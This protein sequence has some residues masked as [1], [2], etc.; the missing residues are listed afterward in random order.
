MVGQKDSV[1]KKIDDSFS[2]IE[3]RLS[4]S[5]QLVK[6]DIEDLNERLEKS[7]KF[8][9]SGEMIDLKEKL[10]IRFA[11]V[12][13]EIENIKNNFAKKEELTNERLNIENELSILRKQIN[14]TG[15][16]EELTTALE[17]KIEEIF[18]NFREEFL[19]YK[20]N[21]SKKQKEFIS[22]IEKEKAEALK[23]KDKEIERMKNSFEQ[24]KKE[25]ISSLN[26]RIE[27]RDKEIA[28]FKGQVNWLKGRFN[29]LQSSVKNPE[30]VEKEEREVFYKNKNTRK[31]PINEEIKYNKDGVN[32]GFISKIIDSLSEE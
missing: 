2:D 30:K 23:E 29:L 11:D 1:E 4:V 18:L 24:D 5:F 12:R 6:R 25:I 8:S 7:K 27:D 13:T 3:K 20:E 21:I 28:S 32:P 16:K 17:K 14:K 26:N 19:A 31:L 10:T 9:P 15:I 22:S